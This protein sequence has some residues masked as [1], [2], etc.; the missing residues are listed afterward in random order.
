MY[1][2]RLLQFYF[3]ESSNP[4]LAAQLSPIAPQTTSTYTYHSL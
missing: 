2:D 1:I 3:G 4:K